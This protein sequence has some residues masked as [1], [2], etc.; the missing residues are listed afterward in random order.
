MRDFAAAF[1]SMPGIQMQFGTPEVAV[2]AS[3]DMGYTMTEGVITMDGP[4]GGTITENMRDF[5]VWKKD[6]DGT[7]K[8][9]VD[10]W[11]TSDPLPGN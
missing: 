7:W 9:V 8:V 4:D 5:H 3:G 10:I 1:T 2:A 6:A 11:N